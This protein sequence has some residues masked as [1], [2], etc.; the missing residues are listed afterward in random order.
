MTRMAAA[1]GGKKVILLVVP[2]AT[3]HDRAHEALMAAATPN[4]ACTTDGLLAVGA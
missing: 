2:P 4:D 3:E 1:A